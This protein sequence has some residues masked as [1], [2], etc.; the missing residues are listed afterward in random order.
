[1]SKKWASVVQGAVEGGWGTTLRFCLII[2]VG[3]VM[4]ALTTSPW[5]ELLHAL[6]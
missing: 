6:Q 4:V 5:T 3:G 1:M 2:V